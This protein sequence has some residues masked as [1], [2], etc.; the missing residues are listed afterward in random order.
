MFCALLCKKA[1]KVNDLGEDMKSWIA[2]IAVV[3]FLCVSY[4]CC[5]GRC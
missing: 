5:F 4:V 3:F 1:Q 2:G